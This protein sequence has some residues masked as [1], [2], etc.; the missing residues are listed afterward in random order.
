MKEVCRGRYLLVVGCSFVVEAGLD[1]VA[2]MFLQLSEEVVTHFCLWEQVQRLVEVV[3]G[4]SRSSWWLEL[5]VMVAHNAELLL[6]V[7][8]MLEHLAELM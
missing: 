1:W 3:P 4:H 7:L 2:G 6:S 5:A 8:E